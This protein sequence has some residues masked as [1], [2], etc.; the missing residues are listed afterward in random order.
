VPNG[1]QVQTSPS[2]T[3]RHSPNSTMYPVV[4]Q[5]PPQGNLFSVSGSGAGGTVQ[6]PTNLVSNLNQKNKRTYTR[7]YDKSSPQYVYNNG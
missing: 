3:G 6:T 5:R 7:A 1:A 2:P 4:Q